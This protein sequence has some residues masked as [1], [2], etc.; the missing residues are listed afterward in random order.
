MAKKPLIMNKKVAR[1]LALS[2]LSFSA[3]LMISACSDS[4]KTAAT[5]T[6]AVS[7]T[8]TVVAVEE[9]AVAAE[10][11]DTEV[12]TA[13]PSVQA[14]A[15]ETSKVTAEPEMVLAADAG[16]QLYNAQCVACHVTGLLNAPKLGDKQAWAPRIA[17]G[18]ETLYMH[19]AQGFNKMPAQA[20]ADVSVEQVHAAVDYMLAA[21]S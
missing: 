1:K 3:L 18:K 21:V 12:A 15:T 8:E 2:A 4:D 5:D 20:N 14:D 19:S 16:E 17:K 9:P 11:T 7:E 13:E 6:A 10:V